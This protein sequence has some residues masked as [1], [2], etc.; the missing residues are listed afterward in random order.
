[1]TYAG[2]IQL[3]S[4]KFPIRKILIITGIT[5]GSVVILLLVGVAVLKS[6]SDEQYHRLV[7]GMVESSTGFSLQTDTF[8]L[9]IGDEILVKAS[10][11]KLTN[12]ESDTPNLLSARELRVSVRFWPLFR[13]VAILDLTGAGIDIQ[14]AKDAESQLNWRT[15]KKRKK[16]KKRGLP[17]RLVPTLRI[18]ESS[19][20]YR[21]EVEGSETGFQV[22]TMS[23]ATRSEPLELDFDGSVNGLPL[24][25]EGTL[26]D[27]DARIAGKPTDVSVRAKIKEA[28]LSINGS[29]ESVIPISGADL[30]F[31]LDVTSVAAL[32]QAIGLKPRF[33]LPRQLTATG[34]LS[35]SRRALVLD[36]LVAQLNDKGIEARVTGTADGLLTRDN[37]RLGFAVQT[38]S[39]T[40]LSKYV[41]REMPAL[42][43]VEGTGT[44]VIDANDVGIEDLQVS[45]AGKQLTA[46]FSGAIGRVYPLR[47]MDDVMAH[48]DLKGE[49]EAAIESLDWLA[50]LTG[51]QMPAPGMLNL[52]AELAAAGAE[53][54][55]VRVKADFS[56]QYLSGKLQGR[57]PDLDKPAHRVLELELETE[58][59]KELAMLI[60]KEIDYEKPAT[61]TAKVTATPEDY[62]ADD[63]TLVVDDSELEGSLVYRMETEQ[64]ARGLLTA[65]LHSPRLDLSFLLAGLGE[66]GSDEESAQRMDAMVL[67]EEEMEAFGKVDDS[68]GEKQPE[69]PIRKLFSTGPLDLN[70]LHKIDAR[71]DID[72]DQLEFGKTDLHDLD[73]HLVLDN[74]L[75]TIQPIHARGPGTST[76]DME[77]VLDG[78]R[79]LTKFM[80][81]LDLGRVEMPRLG[82]ITDLEM[83][84][85]G[86][87]GS[88]AELMGSLGGKLQARAIDGRLESSFLTRFG[89][90]IFTSINPL[91]KKQ[92]YT[93]LDCAVMILSIEDGIILLDEKLALQTTD[94][95]WFGSGGIDLNTEEFEIVVQSV[96]RKGVG[97]SLTS[98]FSKMVYMT[99]T[100][101]T[102][103]IQLNPRELGAK[104]FTSY[105]HVA[106]GGL[107]YLWEKLRN[108]HE[109]NEDVCAKMLGDFEFD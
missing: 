81:D 42:G 51:R 32:M 84:I 57:I 75:L 6:L 79:E 40:H 65:N 35:G 44:L 28:I 2:D 95:T 106:S 91:S 86:A 31:Q 25:L 27:F 59:L 55:G 104:L 93:G 5:V 9:D 36:Q 4:Q 76:L 58:S 63:F 60:G 50:H 26:G 94:V 16:G 105:L 38:D 99:G 62:Q 96:P 69:V 39:A 33:A 49:L 24:E 67:T 70:W 97:I 19:I 37:I 22:N 83:R 74:G 47:G 43:R 14:I 52:K 30:D 77:L 18:S 45:L 89:R 66:S 82:G 80:F 53:D 68:N 101:A 103:I 7:V 109:A 23:I 21:N 108:K 72:A 87:G 107:T 3:N 100:L 20:T 92:D 54:D 11:I 12:P 98:D 13:G 15:A 73:A 34:R 48:S 46:K 78:R 10:G 85:N 8:D 56:N 102:P 41:R 29:I 1:M 61:L 17:V 88:V 64:V 90:D 71:L